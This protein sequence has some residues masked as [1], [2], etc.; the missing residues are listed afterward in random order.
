MEL[1]DLRVKILEDVVD[2]FIVKEA[3]ETFT[4]NPKRCL[5]ASYNH[6]KVFTHK[7]ELPNDTSWKRDVYQKAAQINLDEFDVAS[8]SLIMMS[9]IDEI[10]NQDAIAR[11]AT[12]LE[13]GSVY[14]FMQRMFQRFLNVEQ[15][16]QPWNG[17]R[18]CRAST[19]QNLAESHTRSIGDGGWH[20]SF[21]GD[22]EMIIDKIKSY[23]HE[24]FNTEETIGLINERVAN[25]QD[26]LGRTFRFRT[27]EIDETFPKYVRENQDFLGHLIKTVH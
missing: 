1:L 18:I 12:E 11:A 20:W 26:I 13:E 4:G 25:S 7:V 16:G 22:T 17:T 21:L 8:D 23:A 5:A 15:I 14:R 9:D 3:D 19:Y 2:K 27:V 6:P 24:Q 10:P